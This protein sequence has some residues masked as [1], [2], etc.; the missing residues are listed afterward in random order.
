MVW[1]KLHHI[2]WYCHLRTPFL[3]QSYGG[4]SSIVFTQENCCDVRN[5]V[6]PPCSLMWWFVSFQEGSNFIKEFKFDPSRSVDFMERIW[7][8]LES[9]SCVRTAKRPLPV[10]DPF[11]IYR[12]LRRDGKLS[13]N[14]L[15]IPREIES[16]KNPSAMSQSGV[17]FLAL[18]LPQ[19]N[20]I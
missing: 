2:V 3:S 18:G 14:L 5:K 8:R 20:E 4:K 10:V 16:S 7:F 6:R 9:T 19:G 1:L 17:S 15:T 12:N 13:P 11:T